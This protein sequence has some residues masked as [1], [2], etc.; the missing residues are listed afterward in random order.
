MTSEDRLEIPESW[1]A[2]LPP[3]RGVRPGEP[4]ELDPK[5]P[6]LVRGRLKSRD[7]DLRAA[8]GPGANTLHAAAAIRHLDGEP[9]PAGPRRSR[10]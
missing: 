4:G 7:A 3:R 8:F 2:E 5:A 10:P 1:L 6:L 9:D